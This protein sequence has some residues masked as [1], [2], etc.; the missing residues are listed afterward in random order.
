VKEMPVA[1]KI[2]SAHGMPADD[3]VIDARKIT[4]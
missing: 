3:E 4:A 2:G 1:L